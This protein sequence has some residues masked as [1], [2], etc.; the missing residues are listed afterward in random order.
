MPTDKESYAY[1]VWLI[2][3]SKPF[4][5]FIMGLIVIN[6]VVLMMEVERCKYFDYH[7]C[8][9]IQHIFHFFSVP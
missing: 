4:E 8:H 2:V 6:T 9:F 5:F 1:K 7:E 3:V